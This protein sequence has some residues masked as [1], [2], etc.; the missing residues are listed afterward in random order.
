MKIQEQFELFRNTLGLFEID[1][2]M[3]DSCSL[4]DYDRPEYF[5]CA[6]CRNCVECGGCECEEGQAN[7]RGLA[8]QLL[9]LVGKDSFIHPR[10]RRQ[11]V[12]RGSG[13]KACVANLQN[14]G[15]HT[16]QS[17]ARHE[18]SSVCQ[19]GIGACDRRW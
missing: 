7:G 17:V 16:A 14:A 3:C 9:A 11:D 1:K 6:D 19:I 13:R 10:V 2:D 12:E 8:S 15:W 18:P 5:V 4:T